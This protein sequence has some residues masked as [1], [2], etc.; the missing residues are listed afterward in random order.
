MVLDRN[1][2]GGILVQPMVEM[3]GIVEEPLVEPRPDPLLEFIEIDNGLGHNVPRYFMEFIE[4][5]GGFWLSGPPIS[6]VHAQS[7]GI[8][9]QYFANLSLEFDLN[10]P[11]GSRLSLTPLGYLYKDQYYRP[12]KDFERSQRLDNAKLL[13]Y[14]TISD[15]RKNQ[16]QTIV[17]T[18]YQDGFPLKN[19]E[20]ILLMKLPDG[21]QPTYRFPPTDENGKT[22]LTV[23]PINN[24]PRYTMIPY[25]VCLEAEVGHDQCKEENFAIWK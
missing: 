22:S 19:R 16:S 24:A 14:E 8:Y 6:E 23:P 25:E 20:P 1:V 10:K 15:L 11:E 21:S 9:R 7:S 4:R 2:P 17:V 18:I 5:H 13:I 12:E 3:L